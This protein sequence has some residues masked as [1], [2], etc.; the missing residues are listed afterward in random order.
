MVTIAPTAEQ[1][2]SIILTIL[3]SDGSYEDYASIR[4]LVSPSFRNHNINNIV[5]TV[6]SKGTLAFDD[7]PT[8][9]LGDGF[10]FRGG[11]NLLFEAAFMAA[12]GSKAVVDVARDHTQEQQSADFQ[13]LQT[14]TVLT[15]GPTADQE[16]YS[17]F[18]DEFASPTGLGLKVSLRTFAYRDV[19]DNNYIVLRYALHNTGSATLSNLHTGLYFD[20]DLGSALANSARFDSEKILGYVYDV[21]AGGIPTHV[22]VTVLSHPSLPQFRAISNPATDP[23]NWGVWDGFTKEEKWIALSSGAPN[24]IAF[25]LLIRTR[26]NRLC[27]FLFSSIRTIR[28]RS[29]PPP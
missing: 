19:P 17:L 20:W 21:A 6:T 23:V 18:W 22:G 24:G 8:N 4:I 28:I 5:M 15:P 14:V 12:T 26:V 13:A 25:P 11:N 7:Y 27:R 3:V 9:A 2:S 29:I 1:N 16:T 10:I